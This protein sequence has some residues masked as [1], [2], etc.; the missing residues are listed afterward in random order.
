MNSDRDP[1]E[2][3]P[4]RVAVQEESRE[5]PDDEAD[6][7]EPTARGRKTAVVLSIVTVL[8]AT[9]VGAGLLWAGGG[10]KTPGP[11]AGPKIRQVAVVKTDISGVREMEGT[12][13]YDS[14]RTIR[15]VGEGV[16]TWLPKQ[17]VTVARGEQLYRVDERPTVVFY[18]STPMYRRLDTPGSVGRDVRV[19]AD[20]LKAVGYDIGQ[21]PAVGAVVRQRAPVDQQ[22]SADAGS[23]TASEAD[24]TAE[25]GSGPPPSAQGD[26]A[27]QET[28]AGQPAEDRTGAGQSP[29][30][31]RQ[32][33]VKEGDGVLTEGLMAAIKRWQKSLDIEPTGILESSDVVV[34]RSAVRVSEVS[35]Q[36]GDA[37]ANDLL[38]VSA[39]TKS[40]R[41]PVETLDLGTIKAGQ[42]V[43][44]LLPDGTETGGEVATIGTTIKADQEGESGTGVSKINVTV[45]VD[46]AEA[47]KGIDAAPVQV[48]FEA[49]AKKGVLA[50]PVGALL[51]LREGGYAV[52]L[53]EGRSADG[54]SAAGRLVPVE[55]GMFA[56]GVVE[57]SGE[58]ITEGMKVEA[59]A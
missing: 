20:N 43:T 44:V 10:G 6:L 32:V 41:I 37:A 7:P 3:M 25:P 53:A 12:L 49:E 51:A 21:Q 35:A 55:T 56:R 16:V 42:K 26:D 2:T 5:V 18:G 17:G 36:T 4:L 54:R 13:G 8:L 22:T 47:V 38:S 28:G 15:G 50:V 40:V 52:R 34:T 46:D 1:S 58:D 33:T 39:T 27:G 30:P 23:S 57:I 29:T 48:R 24:Q 45:S 14:V 59:T 31:A 11:E 19:V 9:G